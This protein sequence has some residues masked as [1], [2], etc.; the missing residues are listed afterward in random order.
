MLE[1]RLRCGQ[2]VSFDGRVLEI[3]RGDT[4]SAR[5]HVA[6]LGA[7]EPVEV[8]DGSHRLALDGGSVTLEF[9]REEAPAC[10]RL[11][12][13]LAEAAPDRRRG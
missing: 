1:V 10:A 6:Q 7:P 3:F 4:P 5:F 8:A 9:A 12:A 2:V 13:A 11:T